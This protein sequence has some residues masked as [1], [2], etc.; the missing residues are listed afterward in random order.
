MRGREVPPRRPSVPCDRH[1]S[2]S[3]FVVCE[4]PAA[5]R[6]IRCWVVPGRD[7]SSSAGSVRR[8]PLRQKSPVPPLRGKPSACLYLAAIPPRLHRGEPRR[9]C[10]GQPGGRRSACWR[11]AYSPSSRSVGSPVGTP[12]AGGTVPGFAF[13]GVPLFGQVSRPGSGRGCRLSSRIVGLFRCSREPCVS[14]PRRSRARR[15]HTARLVAVSHRPRRTDPAGYETGQYH[16]P[17]SI[18]R[19]KVSADASSLPRLDGRKK[20]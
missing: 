10:S 14:L 11:S 4:H 7:S 15:P 8:V 3:T 16:R 18:S 17:T 5:L 12:C 20:V 1:H 19:P 6:S 2:T 9:K 13:N